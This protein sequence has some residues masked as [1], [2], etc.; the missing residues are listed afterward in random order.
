MKTV[1]LE[2]KKKCRKEIPATSGFVLG[3]K[4]N[5]VEF[6]EDGLRSEDSKKLAI[7][8]EVLLSGSRRSVQQHGFDFIEVSGG[9]YE[10]M[11]FE[12]VKESTRKREAYFIEFAEDVRS[13][14]K[15]YLCRSKIPSSS[16]S[17]M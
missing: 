2:K 7:L 14:F 4:L 17:F 9:N 8:L 11:A 10:R 16:W 13:F 15:K 12:H 5:S 3:I 1:F 6:Q